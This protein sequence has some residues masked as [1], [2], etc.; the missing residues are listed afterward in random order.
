MSAFFHHRDTEI[1]QSFTEQ[2]SVLL[3]ASLCASV[4]KV[5]LTTT[6]IEAIKFTLCDRRFQLE[7]VSNEL[8]QLRPIP[9]RI[10]RQHAELILNIVL[11]HF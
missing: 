5:S 3:C 4:V 6:A 7:F 2:N 10:R 11:A 9:S 1:T 8:E